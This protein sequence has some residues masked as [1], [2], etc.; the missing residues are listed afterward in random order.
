MAKKVSRKM[1]ALSSAGILT[2]SCWLLGSSVLA[3]TIQITKTVTHAE[4]KLAARVCLSC[5]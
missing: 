4:D 3:Y 1:A 5:W 2:V